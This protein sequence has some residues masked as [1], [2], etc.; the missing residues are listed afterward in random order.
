MKAL[1]FALTWCALALG[2]EACHR[3]PAQALEGF[4]PSDGVVSSRSLEQLGGAQLA[5]EIVQTCGDCAK[6]ARPGAPVGAPCL[7][8]SVCAEFCCDC[9]N[10]LTKSYRAR[11]CDAGHCAGAK[12]CAAARAAIRPDVCGP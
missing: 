8:P 11:V 1:G 3:D 6:S 2:P 12:S 5:A 4:C 9:A 7:A 10:S